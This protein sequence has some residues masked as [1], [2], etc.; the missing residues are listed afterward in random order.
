MKSLNKK[1]ILHTD[2][3]SEERKAENTYHKLLN[4]YI[5]LVFCPF[6]LFFMIL[7]YYRNLFFEAF[8]LLL[9]LINGL[10]SVYLGY[11]LKNINSLI[12]LKRI[13]SAIAFC[14][15][16]AIFINGLVWINLILYLPWI[17]LYPLPVMLFFG[18]RVGFWWALFFSIAAAWI[19]ITGDISVLPLSDIKM[20]KLHAVTVLFS[21]LGIALISE[22]IRLRVQNDLV[23]VQK[24]YKEAEN[25]QNETN[26]NLKNEIDL[27]I[28]SEKAL[29]RSESRYRALFEESPIS[30][31]EEDYSDI[32]K[33]L[34]ALSTDASGDLGTYFDNNPEALEKC[35]GM[36][37]VE[38]VNRATLKLYEAENK[39]TLM[40]NIGT[41]LS[42]DYLDFFKK[43]LVSLFYD[44]SY[45]TERPGKTLTGKQI[46]ILLTC[47]IPTGYEKSWSKIFVSIHDL[48]DRVN[49]EEEKKKVEQQ[50]QQAQ[51][52][53]ATATLGGGIA[54]EFNNALAV[55]NGNLD[56]LRMDLKEDSS[57][58]EYVEPMKISVKRMSKLTSQLLAYAQGG[59]FQPKK[60]SINQLLKETI[61]IK[62]A[63]RKPSI[64]LTTDLIEDLCSV[65]GDITQIKMVFEAILANASESIDKA[66]KI[67]ISTRNQDIEVGFN[68]HYPKLSAS[69]YAVVTIKDSGIGM[70]EETCNRIFEPFFTT[71]IS[72]RGL[73]MSAAHGIVR[74]H[75]GTIYVKSTLHK[76]T[77]VQVYLP[78]ATS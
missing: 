60:F 78:E 53:Q 35:R 9:M 68:A 51:I 62:E 7:S 33:F 16:A 74:N 72:G 40:R 15:L 73:G 58:D 14:I 32:K 18:K 22:K 44:G 47:K 45:F 69:R 61:E 4:P 49:I 8:L 11:K 17:F 19:V 23:T 38:D 56:L 41:I 42:S 3:A 24:N 27:R 12:M 13:G 57:K 70:D 46:H 67:H 20:F 48:T 1:N 31:W 76:G 50:L 25:R 26:K 65:K 71:K 28:K 21:L 34:D 2:S 36:I 77:M 55:I 30:L 37:K 54:H 52:L 59:K 66:G 6:F 29:R 75:G 63:L 10:V 64:F 39:E 43:R 5:T